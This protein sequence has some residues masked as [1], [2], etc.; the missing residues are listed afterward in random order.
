MLNLRIHTPGI[1]IIRESRILCLF[2]VAAFLFIFTAYYKTNIK[3][4]DNICYKQQKTS[5]C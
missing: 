1:F 4:P 2:I 3:I 5:A